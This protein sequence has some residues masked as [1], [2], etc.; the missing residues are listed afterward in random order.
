MRPPR[1]THIGRTGRLDG[2]VLRQARP[3]LWAPRQGCEHVPVAQFEIRPA[4][5][6]DARA[7]AELFASVAEERDGIAT[8][9]PVDVGERAALFVRSAGEAGGAGGRWA[10]HRG[11]APLCRAAG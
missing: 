2:L 9:P 6:G 5:A 8:E 3:E 11:G 7:M 10:T 4:Q 1:R